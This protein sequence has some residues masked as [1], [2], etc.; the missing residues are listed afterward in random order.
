V[1]VLYF[2][3]DYTPHDYRFLDS[4][5]K[6][7]HEV[8]YLRL[9]NDMRVQEKRS[10]PSNIEEVVWQGGRRKITVTDGLSLV[11]GLRHVLGEVRPDLVHAGPIQQGAFLSALTGY[12]PLI[13]MS[14]GS[15]LLVDAAR[16][17]GKWVAK[18]TLSRSNVLICDCQIVSDAAQQLGMPAERIVAFPWGIELDHFIPGGDRSMRAKLGWE[19]H[20]VLLSTRSWEPIYG[21]E[22]LVAGFIQASQTNPNLRLLMLGSGSLRPRIE[23]MLAEVEMLEHV[24]FAGQVNYPDLPMHYHTADLYISASRSDGTSISLLEAMACGLP[25]VVSDIPGNREWVEPGVNGWWF[26]DGDEVELAKSINLAYQ[27]EAQRYEFGQAGRVI[28]ERRADWKRNFESL[29]EAYELAAAT[30]RVIEG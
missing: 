8:Y 21:I 1:R 4:L 18:Y 29:L 14:W 16:G 3:R 24:H 12:K 20:F 11:F 10:L 22:I 6:T 28:A 7:E 5:S 30:G 27:T 15:D 25:V 17:V 19:D 13:A 2:S 26:P 9:E 23:A